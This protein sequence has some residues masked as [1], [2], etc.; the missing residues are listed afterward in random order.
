MSVS[1][2]LMVLD[3]RLLLFCSLV[4][5]FAVCEAWIGFLS[6]GSAMLLLMFIR[7]GV[8][9]FDWVR[10]GVPVFDWV[11]GEEVIL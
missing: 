2:P 7:G 6:L 1:F 9:V 4:L 10:G 8:P 5:G 3:A 11:R